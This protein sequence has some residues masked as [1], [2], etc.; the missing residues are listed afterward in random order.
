MR[1]QGGVSIDSPVISGVSQGTELDPLLFMILI[2]DINSGITSSSMDLWSAL[3]M[4]RDY[5]MVFQK[6]MIVLF[7]LMF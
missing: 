2:C 1:L 5:T 3:L 7:F 4:I 6:L